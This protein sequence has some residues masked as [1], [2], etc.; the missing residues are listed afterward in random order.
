MNKVKKSFME[1]MNKWIIHKYDPVA[2]RRM[3]KELKI[4]QV[5]MGIK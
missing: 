2:M 3:D 4:S 1:N 5:H